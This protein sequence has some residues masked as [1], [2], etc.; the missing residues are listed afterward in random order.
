MPKTTSSNGNKVANTT[1]RKAKSSRAGSSLKKMIGQFVVLGLMVVALPV[2]YVLTQQSQDTRSDASTFPGPLNC[3][4]SEV[5][6]NNKAA[7]SKNHFFLCPNSQIRGTVA[8][9]EQWDIFVLPVS[10]QGRYTLTSNSTERLPLYLYD[11][12]ESKNLIAVSSNWDVNQAITLDLAPD[13]Y[14]VAVF[15]DGNNSRNYTLNVQGPSEQA[16]LLTCNSWEH[17][18]INACDSWQKY[19]SNDPSCNTASNTVTL[20]NNVREATAMYITQ[21][22]RNTWCDQVTNWGPVRR[23][24]PA[25][26]YDLQGGPGEYKLCAKFVNAA[27]EARCGAIIRK[28]N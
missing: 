26:N 8:E 24:M 9:G 7:E 2:G 13:I 4:T 11:A 23:Y 5:E 3:L 1:N 28:T 22:D 10:V 27:G 16:N 12:T 19:S 17:A 18:S 14:H 6:P 25:D 20:H 21:V 15:K